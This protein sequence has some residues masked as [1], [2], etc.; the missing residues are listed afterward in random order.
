MSQDS[1]MTA[2]RIESAMIAAMHRHGQ[3]EIARSLGLSE[4]TVSEMK[5][6]Q[7]PL[8][9]KLLAV[10]GLKVVERSKICVRPEEWALVTRIASR[11]LA[12]EE[13][14]KQLLWEDPT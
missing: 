1:N 5:G 10:C 11:A 4:S 14:A 6:K 13:A 9:A 7:I 2:A 12:N 3:I 8:V